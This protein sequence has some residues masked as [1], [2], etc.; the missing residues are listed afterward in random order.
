LGIV[1]SARMKALNHLELDFKTK[2]EGTG[3]QLK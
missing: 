1:S 3:Q 2:A